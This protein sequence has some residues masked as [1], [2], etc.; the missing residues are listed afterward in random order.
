MRFHTNIR[1]LL[2]F[3]LWVGL[4]FLGI[5]IR[6]VITSASILVIFVLILLVLVIITLLVESFT[7]EEQHS[8]R[9]NAF[10][11]VV[12]DFKINSQ[13]SLHII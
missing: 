3:T 1:K 11:N 4:G 6:I 5:E 7:G 10:P 8:S 2:L 9:H 13:K 12:A